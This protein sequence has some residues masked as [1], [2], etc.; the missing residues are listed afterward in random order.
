MQSKLYITFLI[1]IGLTSINIFAQSD[2]YNRY[3]VLNID[4][5]KIKSAKIRSLN[6]YEYQDI[7]GF[8]D[9]L[10]S[11]GI[12]TAIDSFDLNGN[13][14]KSS[15]F[16]YGHISVRE[17]FYNQQNELTEELYSFDGVNINKTFVNYDSLKRI[18]EVTYLQFYSGLLSNYYFLYDSE[19]KLTGTQFCPQ[20]GDCMKRERI[21]YD[22]K[23]NEILL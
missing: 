7:K 3:S 4:N 22:D 13:V 21:Y 8:V 2:T 5:G 19:G 9:T 10:K 16:D 12:L 14:L 23:N 20:N 1:I 15:G 11:N 17:Y 18:N 6:L